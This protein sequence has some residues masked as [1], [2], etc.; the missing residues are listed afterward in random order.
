MR[1]F[2]CPDGGV[3]RSARGGQD[4]TADLAELDRA[5]APAND[6]LV[7]VLEK[8][9][10]DPSASRI[11]SVPLRVSS[12]SDPSLPRDRPGDRPDAIRSPVRTLAPLT[13]ACAS[14]CGIV[15]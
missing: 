5:R 2:S 8:D 7:A 15:Q 6:D 4:A 12:I 11:G 14:C 3:R 10:S 13:V 9:R 1:G